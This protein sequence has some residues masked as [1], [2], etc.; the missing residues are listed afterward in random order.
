MWPAREPEPLPNI[1][2]SMKHQMLPKTTPALSASS[3]QIRRAEA[4]VNIAGGSVEPGAA[5]KLEALVSE[6]GIEVRVTSAE[7][8]G[9][10]AAVRKAVSAAPDLVIILARGRYRA[11]C[12]AIVRA[13]RPARGILAG[14]DHECASQCAL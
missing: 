5:E 10:D 8:K 2:S 1:L 6:F 13:Q 11:S 12:G 3:I 14:G 4:V 7:P 9:I